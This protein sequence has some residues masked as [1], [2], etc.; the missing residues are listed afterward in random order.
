MQ[1]TTTTTQPATTT[2]TQ[3][4]TTT[5]SAPADQVFANGFES[6]L[7]TVW[8]SSATNNGKLSITAGSALSGTRGLSA[9]IANRN[10]EYVDD[11]TPKALKTY[12]ARFQFDPNTVSI[13]SGKSHLIF[14][15]L[16]SGGK[17]SVVIQVRKA[18]LGYEIQAGALANNGT[19]KYTAWKAVSDAPHT[20]EIGWAA[21]TTTSGTN[22]STTLWVDGLAASTVSGIANGSQRIDDA[23]LGPQSIPTG[24][25]G[26]EYFDGFVSTVSSYIGL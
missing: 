1:P 23:R 8:S 14:V 7:L 24:V 19:V 3:P 10:D 9:A 13:A 5:T 6:G 20:I 12:H 17:Q 4:T 25:A 11:A 22:G 21:A 18:I 2:T 15:G 16:G 26:T